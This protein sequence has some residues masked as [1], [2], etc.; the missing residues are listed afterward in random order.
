MDELAQP[1]Q[2]LE[3]M[4]K[5]R[6]IALVLLLGIGLMLIPDTPETSYDVP[7][8][9][10]ETISVSL[11]D[12]LSELLSRMDGAG[13]VQVLLTEAKGEAIHY[14]QDEDHSSS[15]QIRSDT[16]VITDS[17]REESGLIRQKESPVYQGAVVLCQG[18]DNPSVR[19]AIV[20]AVAN[21]T[22]LS[23]DKI[24]VLKMKS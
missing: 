20:Q 19:L 3:F 21:A 11:Q 23:T 15:G 2:I 9:S 14:Q 5:Y 6:Y 17:S 13:K 22:G 24:S 12:S 8:V 4:K 18:A 10:L 16:V 1:Q 7:V